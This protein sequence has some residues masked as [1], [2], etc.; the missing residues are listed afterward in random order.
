[1]GVENNI[2]QIRKE[3][4]KALEMTINR[5]KISLLYLQDQ[6]G[7]MQHWVSADFPGEG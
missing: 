7:W 2:D 4:M 1:M 3:K 6:L 5:R